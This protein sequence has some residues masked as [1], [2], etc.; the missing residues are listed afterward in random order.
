MDTVKVILSGADD[1]PVS[2]KVNGQ[3]LWVPK[4]VEVE[5]PEPVYFVLKNTY[6][7]NVREDGHFRTAREL[8]D[9][10]GALLGDTPPAQVVHQCGSGVSA[11]HNLVAMSIAGLPGAL[12][13]PGVQSFT[14]KESEGSSIYH[15]GVL[16]LR[17]RMSKGM[18]VGGSY[19]Y[20]KSIDDLGGLA[21]DDLNPRAERA[22]SSGDMRHQLQADYMYELPFG[23]GKRFLDHGGLLAQMFGDWTW[24]GTMNVHS[25]SPL[26]ILV[27]N[28]AT[29]LSG[30]GRSLRPD[31]NLSEALLLGESGCSPA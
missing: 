7:Q 20:S 6:K 15:A 22:L 13:Y 10:F 9:A 19:T 8:R 31:R 18:S 29:S 1:I 3:E 14:W 24:T 27:A 2:V 16:R 30:L 12:L 17:K 11:C 26:N 21:Q 28:D 5:V 4:N 23:T 25:G